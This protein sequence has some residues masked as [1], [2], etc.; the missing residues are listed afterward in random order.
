MAIMVQ[1]GKTKDVVERFFLGKGLSYTRPRQ[2]MGDGTGLEVSLAK[3][4]LSFGIQ[5]TQSDRTIEAY[6][7]PSAIIAL[8]RS[9]DAK[10]PSVGHMR[11]TYARDGSLLPVIR[12]LISNTSEHIERCFH[13]IPPLE[14][15]RLVLQYTIRLRDMVGDLQDNALGVSEDV[16]ELLPC[17]QSDN[18]HHYWSLPTIE[19]LQLFSPE[20]LDSAVNESTQSSTTAK[21]G[22]GTA[23][24][25]RSLVSSSYKYYLLL[26]D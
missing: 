5:S 6:K 12:L 19:P 23:T 18:F 14:G 3:G 24:Q 17:L 1:G 26:L 7:R 10:S 22:L 13:G 4:P 25:K 8:D 16:E 11:T 15:L 20:E 21:T 9:F 2:E